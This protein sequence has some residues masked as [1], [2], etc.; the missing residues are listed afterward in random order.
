MTYLSA[1]EPEF[2]VGTTSGYAPYVSLDGEGRYEGFDIDFANAL[3]Q[4]LGQKLVIK[5]LGSMP[6]LMLA[7]QQNKIDALIWAVSITPER[8]QKMRMIYY[9]GDKVTQMPFLFWKKAPKEIRSIDDLKGRTVSVEAL[10]F[11]ESVLKKYPD[12]QLKQVEKISDGI[13]EIRFGKSFATMIDPSLVAKWTAQNPNLQ[14]VWLPLKPDEYALGN[15]ICIHK[16]KSDLAARI[17][18]ATEKLI[19]EGKVLELEQKW[20][21]RN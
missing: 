4:K 1:T 11:Q 14:V 5:D 19:Q 10:S 6:S 17:E 21:L 7:L 20:G 15:G 2:V 8:T 16:N 13:M 12:T 18:A 9:Q 3:A